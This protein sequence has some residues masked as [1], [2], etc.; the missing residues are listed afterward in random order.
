[1]AFW[2]A[3][4][5][6]KYYKSLTD[7]SGA[8]KREICFRNLNNFYYSKKKKVYTMLESGHLC[9][10]IVFKCIQTQTA[11]VNTMHASRCGRCQNEG[12]NT[13]L[14]LSVVSLSREKETWT[15]WE[16]HVVC[17]LGITNPIETWLLPCLFRLWF[18]APR[19]KPVWLPTS[20]FN[21]NI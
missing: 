12:H 13:T 10:I 2:C 15:L 9:R 20:S 1:M 5:L 11:N 7:I 17:I 3:K 21:R 4:P 16:Q 18:D 8:R 6:K 19:H 14:P